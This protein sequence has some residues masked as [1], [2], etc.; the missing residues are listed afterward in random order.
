VAGQR[1]DREPELE[2]DPVQETLFIP[3]YGRATL[4]RQGSALIDDPRAV[5][6]VEAI[7]HDWARFDGLPSL[8]GATLRTRILDH[9]IA[10]WLAD[11]PDGTVVEIGAGLNTRFERVDN[12]RARWFELDLPAAMALRRRFF[13]DGERRTMISG[14]VVDRDW[15]ET[16][17]S[18]SGPFFIVAEAVLPFLAE[19]EVAHRSGTWRRSPAAVS[20]STPGR[21]GWPNIRTN[22][23]R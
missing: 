2:L 9:W 12:G 23:T 22:T 15:V 19:D 5:E 17:I 14:S 11:N 13:E 20:R 16:A 4:T 8:F 10:A 3:L 6:L 7:D 1:L 21:P 18:S